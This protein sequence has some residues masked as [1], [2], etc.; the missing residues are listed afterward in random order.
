[1]RCVVVRGSDRPSL[2]QN[3]RVPLRGYTG[4][5]AQWL[6]LPGWEV[7]HGVEA[8][9]RAMF[10]GLRAVERGW[11]GDECRRRLPSHVSPVALCVC[12]KRSLYC[13][14]AL[15]WACRT[16]CS[17]GELLRW[18]AREE[19]KRRGIGAGVAPL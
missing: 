11:R 10:A 8:K 1:M 2:A 5:C 19:R 6:V 15:C 18:Q 3:C 4:T 7:V 14:L 9:L 12:R 17:R 16:S 13:P